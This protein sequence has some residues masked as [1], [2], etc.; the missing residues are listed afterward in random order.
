MSGASGVL[1]EQQE[2]Q[3]EQ[4][5]ACTAMELNMFALFKLNMFKISTR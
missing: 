3:E 5:S 4:E 1:K 2:Q